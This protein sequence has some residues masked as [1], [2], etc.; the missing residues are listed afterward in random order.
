[1]RTLT[2]KSTAGSSSS[3]PAHQVSPQRRQCA[4]AGVP[5][6]PQSGNTGL[7]GGGQPHM[8]G[9]EV[10]LHARPLQRPQAAGDRG[11]TG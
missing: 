8:G 3:Y 2:S 1:M 7:T 10:V 6:V 11:A 9:S 4:E 5:V